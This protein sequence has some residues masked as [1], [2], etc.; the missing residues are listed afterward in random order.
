MFFFLLQNRITKKKVL[1]QLRSAYDKVSMLLLVYH[2][3]KNLLL[4]TCCPIF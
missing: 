1:S 3:K 2:E 4:L